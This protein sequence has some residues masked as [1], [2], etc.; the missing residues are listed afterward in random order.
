MT[1]ENSTLSRCTAIVCDVASILH[2]THLMGQKQDGHTVGLFRCTRFHAAG[3]RSVG[4]WTR[5][6]WLILYSKAELQVLHISWE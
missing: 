4:I 6:L 5:L 3:A 1:N 2:V